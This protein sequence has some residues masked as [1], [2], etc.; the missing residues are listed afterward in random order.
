MNGQINAM[1]VQ[2]LRTWEWLH[3]STWVMPLWLEFLQFSILP[4]EEWTDAI[5]CVAYK[6]QFQLLSS[7]QWR[8]VLLYCSVPRHKIASHD[9]CHC[10]MISINRLTVIL[11][12]HCS[13]IMNFWLI[14]QHALFPLIKW[15]KWWLYKCVQ[16]KARRMKMLASYEKGHWNLCMHIKEFYKFCK[17]WLLCR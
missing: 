9:L 13:R 12:T 7:V 10:N 3:L 16:I 8:W 17:F 2:C 5:T 1:C 14:I 4:Q 11:I 15:A 6:Q